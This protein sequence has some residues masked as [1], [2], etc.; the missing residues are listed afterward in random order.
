MRRA[1][2]T[3][4]RI[5]KPLGEVALALIVLLL[6]VLIPTLSGSTGAVKTNLNG[7][8]LSA[9]A[10]TGPLTGDQSLFGKETRC[11][12]SWAKDSANNYV[13]YWPA[14]GAPEHTDNVRSGLMP[15]A[16]FTGDFNGAN[17]VFQYKSETTYPGGIGLVVFDGP[18]AGYLWAG[19]VV[20]G[21]GQYVSRFDP[22]DRQG[23]LAHLSVERQ[24]LG[25]VARS[26]Q[27]GDHQ[28]RDARRGRR[29]H[30][31]E[32]RPRRRLHPRLRGAADRRHASDGPQLRRH[33]RRPRRAAARC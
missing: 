17:E 21:A 18:N 15:C 8:V 28:G 25:P 23:D 1:L 10:T 12:E 24:R 16:S 5:V 31:L 14:I 29:A 2:H 26:R 19:G 33:G 9:A 6:A 32:A 4:W 13:G 22:V 7:V 11:V 30:V 20:P 27:P 3:V